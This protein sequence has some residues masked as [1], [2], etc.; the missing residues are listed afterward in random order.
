[1]KKAIFYTSIVLLVLAQLACNAVTNSTQ[2]PVEPTQA[3]AAPTEEANVPSSGNCSPLTLP[4]ET[5]SGYVEKITIARDVEGE[6]KNPVG[7]TKVY[8]TK[9]VF[10][11]VVAIADAPADTVFKA[12]W[13]ATDIG[14]SAS[15]NTHIDETDLT[16]DG[17]RNLDFNL[18]PSEDWP[19][20]SYRV[21]IFVNG[22]LEKIVRFAVKK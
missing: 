17:T 20:G 15:C 18:T 21:E 8:G 16:T 4:E 19:A 13:Y 5:K 12:V 9:D 2:Q 11:A 1:M 3:V 22:T 7:P 6:G 10:H 14:D